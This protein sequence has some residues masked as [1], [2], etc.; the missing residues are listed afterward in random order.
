MEHKG[1]LWIN[2]SKSTTLDAMEKALQS[3]DKKRRIILVVGGKN[4][5]TSF[6]SILPLIQ[7]RVKE[8]IL[9]GEMKHSIA[10]AWHG[11]VSHQVNSIGEAVQLAAAHAEPGDVVLLS[12]GTSS[13]DMFK[14]YE[15]RGNQ[16]K[17]AVQQLLQKTTITC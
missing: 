9:L 17:K 11:I 10:K 1:V 5:G 4:K 8:A 2:D 16:F 12:P 6:S 14:N 7:E 15:E 3:I 13:Y